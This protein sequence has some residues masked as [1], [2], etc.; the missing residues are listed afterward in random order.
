MYKLLIFIPLEA[1]LLLLSA[2]ALLTSF[3]CRKDPYDDK[4]FTIF[5]M[6]TG[7]VCIFISVLFGVGYWLI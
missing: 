6:I 5:L 1:S 4:I 7:I 2:F 3:N